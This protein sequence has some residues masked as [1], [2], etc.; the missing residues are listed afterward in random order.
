MGFISSLFGKSNPTGRWAENTGVPLELNLDTHTLSGAALGS[1]LDQ[2]SFLGPARLS[3][4]RGINSFEFPSK[5]LAIDAD[6]DLRIE[7]FIIFFAAQVQEGFRPFVG[8]VLH[9][10]QTLALGAQ[11]SENSIVREFGEP[12][13]REQDEDEIL[14]FYEFGLVE[15]QFEISLSGAV[16]ALVIGPPLLAD[17]EQRQAYGV[18]KDWPAR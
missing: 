9:K 15:W 11:F 8:R 3:Q 18:T 7:S 5:G 10:G 2:I 16:N 1:P 14:L 13:W 6:R 12:Y 4:V 17:P